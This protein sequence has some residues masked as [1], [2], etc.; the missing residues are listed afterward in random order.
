MS[1]SS[2]KSDSQSGPRLA[3]SVSA[4]EMSSSCFRL[5]SAV[6]KNS[7]PSKVA[8]GMSTNVKHRHLRCVTSTKERGSPPRR[9]LSPLVLIA[10]VRLGCEPIF[11]PLRP[12]YKCAIKCAPL[13]KNMVPMPTI[14]CP[15]NSSM[16]ENSPSALAKSE[17]DH[18]CL[19]HNKSLVL[20][21]VHYTH[22]H[23]LHTHVA[24]PLAARNTLPA[25]NTFLR[26]Q[27]LPAHLWLPAPPYASNRVL[28]V[29]DRRVG[30]G[31]TRK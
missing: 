19:L 25:E 17:N 31:T 14:P 20:L 21:A 30:T 1:K 15:R 29:C 2:P 11:F 22:T 3:I 13:I 18:R 26:P 5:L 23:C 8:L 28:A 16:R 4:Y 12:T 24:S 9:T 10:K 7:D 6:V 27:P